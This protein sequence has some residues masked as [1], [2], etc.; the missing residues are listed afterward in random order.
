M[1]RKVHCVK[2][3]ME[4]DGL[5]SPPMPGE[6]GIKI[7]NEVSQDAWFNWQKQQTMIINENRLNLADKSAR[8]YLKQQMEY[9]FFTK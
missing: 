1:L 8:D 3:D 2:L 7:F 5:A 6:L 9:Y 4:L